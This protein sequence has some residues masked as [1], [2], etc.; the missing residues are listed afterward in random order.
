MNLGLSV[1]L[2]WV[3]LLLCFLPLLLTYVLAYLFFKR[4]CATDPECSGFSAPLLVTRGVVWMYLHILGAD[5][6]VV[7]FADNAFCLGFS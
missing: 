6:L 2:D 3:L 4:V 7:C 1:G 5:V